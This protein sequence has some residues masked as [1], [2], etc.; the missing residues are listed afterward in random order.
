LLNLKPTPEELIAWL[1]NPEEIDKRVR[2]TE[3]QAMIDPH[4]GPQRSGVLGSLNMVA[5]AMKLLP[6]LKS[7]SGA[8]NSQSYHYC[9]VGLKRV[10]RS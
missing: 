6:S 7:Q 4:A 3:M 10:V 8:S 1:C 2:G 9:G 5:D